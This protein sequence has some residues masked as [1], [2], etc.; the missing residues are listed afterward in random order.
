M[1][2]PYGSGNAYLGSFFF[3]PS[4]LN[5]C[6]GSIRFPGFL[7]KGMYV[8][9]CWCLVCIGEHMEKNKQQFSN[10]EYM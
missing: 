1:K 2:A 10:F 7:C 5:T 8:L 3:P 6:H 9:C 4:V